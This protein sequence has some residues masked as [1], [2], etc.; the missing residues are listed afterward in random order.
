MTKAASY[1]L[2]T[3]ILLFIQML[4]IAQSPQL[5]KKFEGIWQVIQQRG[6]YATGNFSPPATKDFKIFDS[7]G[8]FRH[9]INRGDRYLELSRG[10]IKITSDSTYTELLDK[11]LAAS[12]LKEGK[13]I[14]KFVDNDTFLMKWFWGNRNGEEVYKKIK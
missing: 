2:I 4:V 3:A 12:N 9:I 13:V 7:S 10:R 14:F 6:D 11:H 1:I 5:I 8:N